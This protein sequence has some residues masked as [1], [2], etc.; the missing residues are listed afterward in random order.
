M[1]AVEAKGFWGH[2]DGSSPEPTLSAKPTEEETKA[3]NQWAMDECSV[4]TLLTQQLPDLTVMEIHS[5]KTVQERW[6]VVVKEYTKKGVYMQTELWAKFL[7]SRCPEKGNAKD[8]LRGLWLKKEELAQVGVTISDEDYLSTI[9][10]SLPDALSNFASAQ[11]A[12]TMQQTSQLM[13]VNT[14]MSMLLQEAERHNLRAQRHKQGSGKGKDEEQDEALAVSSEQSGGKKGRD[15]SKVKCWNCGEMGHFRNKCPKPK[16]TKAS[17]TAPA[18]V[19]PKTTTDATSR[20]AN[21]IKTM[22]DEEGAWVGEEMVIEDWFREAIEADY[23]EM[24]KLVE[25]SDSKEE[26]NLAV[27]EDELRFEEIVEEEGVCKMT[28]DESEDKV[29]DKDTAEEFGDMS[30]EAF[31]MAELVQ[32]AGMAK[33]YD[34]GCTNHISPYRSQ[35]ENFELVAPQ[36]FRAENKQTFSTIGRVNSL[37]TYQMAK[38]EP[39]NY[40]SR[41]S[42]TLPKWP[43]H[44]YPL[45]S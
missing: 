1:D 42:C 43:T 2:F 33:L 25:A 18:T 11:I 13:D 38:G 7:T 23:A 30:G 16:K 29:E 8:F 6:E 41:M 24:P 5:K 27:L 35:F 10:S 28:S 34:S 40:D 15:S 45:E 39:P 3:K 17:L 20:T 14:L 36:C 9:I 22:S 4:K 26:E 44:L 32:A 37:S 21:T 31:V 19:N 12:W